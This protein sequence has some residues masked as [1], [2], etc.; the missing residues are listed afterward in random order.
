MSA[1]LAVTGIS[2]RFGGLQVLSDVGFAAERG[3]I[4]ALIGPNGAGKT[5]LLNIL[6]GVIRP[7]AGEVRL[8]GVRIDRLS[9]HRIARL[10]LARTFQNLRLFP[11][12]TVLEHVCVALASGP[13]ERRALLASATS[14][15]SV[16][17]GRSILFRLGLDGYRDSRAGA[18]PY[19]L[20]RR[21]EIARA[22]ARTPRLLLLD[23]PSAGL[24]AEDIALLVRLI[25]ELAQEGLSVVLIEHNMAIV[26]N[27]ASRVVVLDHGVAIAS[28]PLAQVAT[29]PAVVEA[30]L[31][32]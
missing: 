9:P 19:G 30:Y 14:P 22:I 31:G 2:H 10:G 4:V 13:R 21:L 18:L 27:L 6:S 3:E 25:G 29:D 7:D 12:L 23:E 11:S 17:E 8:A 16:A 28:G 26:R 1:V 32:D 5:T 20:Q 15:A 24:A